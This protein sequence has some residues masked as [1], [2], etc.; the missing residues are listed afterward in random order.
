MIQ[1]VGI[2]WAFTFIGGLCLVVLGLFS[3]EY[4]KGMSWRKDALGIETSN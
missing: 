1:A 2:S 3:I 4:Y